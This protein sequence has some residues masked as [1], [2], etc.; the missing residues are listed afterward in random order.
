MRVLLDA[1]LR[2]RGQVGAS[3]G[4]SAPTSLR[5]ISAARC[6]WQQWGRAPS[7]AS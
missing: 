4:L 6:C 5:D 3:I 1:L 7:E 2:S